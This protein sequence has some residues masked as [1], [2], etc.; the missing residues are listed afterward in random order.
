MTHQAEK[1]VIL[2][3]YKT[4]T[5]TGRK[6]AETEAKRKAKDI[7]TADKIKRIFKALK[8]KWHQKDQKHKARGRERGESRPPPPLFFVL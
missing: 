6:Q 5:D 8:T 7:A 2:E 4:A 1:I 3:L